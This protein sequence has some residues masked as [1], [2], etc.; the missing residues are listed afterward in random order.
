MSHVDDI[1]MLVIIKNIEYSRC[2]IMVN[3]TIMFCIAVAHVC[4]YPDQWYNG[5]WDNC[6]RIIDSTWRK[7]QCTA[8]HETSS[9]HKTFMSFTFSTACTYTAQWKFSGWMVSRG[10]LRL[11][12]I[13]K[14]AYNKHSIIKRIII[15]RLVHYYWH[16][17]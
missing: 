14:K 2:I 6:R 15:G 16:P 3:K 17:S 11:T 4:I 5:Y 8:F 9:S 13:T 10:L 7:G 12:P 1:I